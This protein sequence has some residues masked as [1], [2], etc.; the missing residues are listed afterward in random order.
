MEKFI[1][2]TFTGVLHT[3]D[4]ADGLIGFPPVAP[5]RRQHYQNIENAKND[6]SFSRK[7]VHSECLG[8]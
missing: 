4:C 5:G 7:H 8:D 2:N 6:S 3:K 1:L